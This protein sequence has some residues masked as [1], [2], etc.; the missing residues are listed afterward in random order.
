MISFGKKIFACYCYSCSI[1]A[2]RIIYWEKEDDGC[3]WFYCVDTA[4]FFKLIIMTV[5]FIVHSH[6]KIA[7]MLQCWKKR[8]VE[9]DQR[10][11]KTIETSGVLKIIK[12]NHTALKTSNTYLF[13]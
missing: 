2:N 4:I 11:S 10:R 3:K 9:G 12:G 7:K 8:V 13:H 1:H 6:I 5:T